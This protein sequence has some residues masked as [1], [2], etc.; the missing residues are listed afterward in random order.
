MT[1]VFD[2]AQE[3]EE[4][5]RQEG[6][7]EHAGADLEDRRARPK[8]LRQRRA[9]HELEHEGTFAPGLFAGAA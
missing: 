1:D 7:R 3:R 5:M 8:L 6:R 9:R 4:E 2:R